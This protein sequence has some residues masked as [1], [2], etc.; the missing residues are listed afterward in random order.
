MRS[1]QPILVE[2][3][4]RRRVDPPMLDELDSDDRPYYPSSTCSRRLP[5]RVRATRHQPAS[6][7]QPPASDYVQGLAAAALRSSEAVVV[8]CLCQEPPASSNYAALRPH[9]D[10]AAAN[11]SPS[12]A[13]SSHSRSALP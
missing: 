12:A 4:R 9:R 5:V 10:P 11:S 3:S 6:R 13:R 1:G 7:N 2:S 8:A